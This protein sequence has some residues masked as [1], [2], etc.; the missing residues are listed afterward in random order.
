MMKI[1]EKISTSIRRFVQL[2]E[3]EL[4]SFLNKLKV[5]LLRRR[6]WLLCEGQICKNAYFINSGCLRYYHVIGGEEITGQFFFE[7]SWYTDYASY[8]SESPSKQYIQA[9][10]KTEVLVLSKIDLYRL[11]DENVKFERFGRLMAEN[12]FLGLRQRTDMLANQ[13]PEERY[14]KLIADRPKLFERVPQHYIAS[15]LGIKP[16]SLSRIR[17]RILKNN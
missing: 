7:G 4:S 8:L 6:E 14:L 17:R 12:A 2:D 16:Q 15:Y 3:A 13:D 1:H 9:I 11:F 5:Q 10:E